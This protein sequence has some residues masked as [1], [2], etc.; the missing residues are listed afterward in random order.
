[1]VYCLH[2]LYL[3]LN[4]STLKQYYSQACVSRPIYIYIYIERERYN[5]YVCICYNTPTSAISD[6]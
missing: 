2:G 1:M 6:L 4:L 5:Y 3:I